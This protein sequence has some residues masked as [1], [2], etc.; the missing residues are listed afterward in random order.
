MANLGADTHASFPW[1]VVGCCEQHTRLS[2]DEKLALTGSLPGPLEQPYN[3]TQTRCTS[4]PLISDPLTTANPQGQPGIATCSRAWHNREWHTLPPEEGMSLYLPRIASLISSHLSRLI[5]DRGIA[6]SGTFFPLFHPAQ[7]L[8]PHVPFMQ[9]S[10]RWC[11]CQCPACPGFPC[12][13]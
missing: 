10:S 2:S 9:L 4:V 11:S 3:P 1:H 7:M 8:F 6:F 5:N 13:P 12:W